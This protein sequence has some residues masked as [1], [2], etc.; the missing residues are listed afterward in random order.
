MMTK[1][2]S[3]MGAVSLAVISMSAMAVPISVSFTGEIYTVGAGVSGSGVSVGD[4]VSGQFVYDTA[5]TDTNPSADYGN[6][7]AQS[8]SISFSSGF[9]AASL[10]TGIMVQNDQQN[11][12][13]TLPADGMIVHANSV[14]GDTLNG[15]SINAYQFGLRKQNVDG[16]LWADDALPDVSDWAG[17]SL[18]DINA[19]DWHWMQ[20]DQLA[21][22]ESIFDSQIRWDISAI[23]VVAQGV[24]EPASVALLGLGLVGL[25]FARK[26][27]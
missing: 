4:T 6:Y 24:P 17:I 13:A 5:T 23:D 16:Q 26:R 18:A 20:F 27:N 12:S 21:S 8:F 7:L 19:P 3:L 10:S 2:L 14:V 9:S 22:D 25:G 11:G 15:R 1:T